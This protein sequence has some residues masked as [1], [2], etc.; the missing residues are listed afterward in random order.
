M[1]SSFKLTLLAA[2]VALSAC[3][4]LE[5]E[6]VDYKSSTKTPSLAVPPI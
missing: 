5:G 6:K 3:S 1:N 4:V 2:A